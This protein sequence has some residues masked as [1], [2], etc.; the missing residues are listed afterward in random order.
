MRPIIVTVL[1]ANEADDTS[2]ISS[3]DVFQN[4]VI[5]KGTLNF[6]LGKNRNIEINIKKNIQSEY[7]MDGKIKKFNGKL[8]MEENRQKNQ[9]DKTVRNIVHQTK[10]LMGNMLGISRKEKKIE[11]VKE[12]T[13]DGKVREYLLGEHGEKIDTNLKKYYILHI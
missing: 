6:E 1:K 13:G 4:L 7:E 12:E 3:Y 10:N 9:Y 8:R 5:K 11:F 2:S